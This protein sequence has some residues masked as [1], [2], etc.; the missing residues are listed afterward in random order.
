[1]PKLATGRFKQSQKSEKMVHLNERAELPFCVAAQFIPKALGAGAPPC[2]FIR[3]LPKK[4]A[5]LRGFGTAEY[6]GR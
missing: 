5:S 1:M 2:Q 3:T 6:S 4:I